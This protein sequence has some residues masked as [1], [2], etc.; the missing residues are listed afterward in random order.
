MTKKETIQEAIQRINQEIGN[1][2]KS[3]Q[4]FILLEEPERQLLV[5][6]KRRLGLGKPR[7]IAIA[8]KY[9]LEQLGDEEKTDVAK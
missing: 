3:V 9:I 8:C 1:N 7:G 6:V 4:E 2:K 5:E